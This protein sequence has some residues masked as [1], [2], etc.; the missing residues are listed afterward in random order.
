MSLTKR[1]VHVIDQI[2]EEKDGLRSFRL[3]ETT[4][5]VF[6]RRYFR[7]GPYAEGEISIQRSKWWTAKGGEVFGELYCFIPEVQLAVH[8]VQQS[9]LAPDPESPL[10][11]FQF[12][13]SGCGEPFEQSVT[14]NDDLSGFEQGLRRWLGSAALPWLRQFESRRG[15]L[16]YVGKQENAFLLALLQAHFGKPS[17]AKQN[18]ARFIEGLPRNIEGEFDTLRARG[19]L[20]EEDHR[21]LLKASIQSN[22]EYGRR[23]QAWLEKREA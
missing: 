15:V 7:Q 4:D 2:F 10:F 8:G 6:F 19:L 5:G 9:W 21:Y 17:Q 1:V 13:T 22:E 12:R 3:V 18:T 11:Y 16:E 14:S 20:S 23:V